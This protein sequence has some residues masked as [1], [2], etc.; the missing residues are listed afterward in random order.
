MSQ[1]RIDDA[2]GACCATSSGWASSAI[3]RRSGRAARIQQ[4]A[5]HRSVALD[6]LGSRWCCCAT[7]TARCRLREA[8]A[9]DIGERARTACLGGYSGG[10]HRLGAGQHAR[11]GRGGRE[12]VGQG[13]RRIPATVAASMQGLHGLRGEYF[14]NKEMSGTPALVRSDAKIDFDWSF[15]SPWR[16][17]AQRTTRCAGPASFCPGDGHA[18]AGLDFG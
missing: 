17:W 7:A 12:E 1:A 5:E 4:C 3:V 15:A 9:R 2:V 8:C 6:A 10:N 16:A 18:H 11:R 13:V 14:A